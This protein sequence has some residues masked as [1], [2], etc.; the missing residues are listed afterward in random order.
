MTPQTVRR[1]QDDFVVLVHG[2]GELD[3]SFRAVPAQGRAKRE[4]DA[5]VRGWPQVS[6]DLASLVGA[7]ND[8]IAN[9]RALADLD[10]LTRPLGISGLRSLPWLLAGAGAAG[11]ATALASLPR[12]R[13]ETR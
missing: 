13:K 2:V 10:D 8:N 1:Q 6:S 11:I 4:I 12:R 7:I 5:L 9:D 3:T